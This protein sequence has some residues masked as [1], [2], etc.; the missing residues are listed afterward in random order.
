MFCPKC[1]AQNKDDQKFCRSCGQ[2]LPAVRMA[3]EGKVDDVATTLTKSL[4]KMASGA[5]TMMIFMVIAF[6]ANLFSGDRVTTT[7]NLFL[8]LLIGAPMVYAGVKRLQGQIKMLNPNEQPKSLPKT[9]PAVLVQPETPQ[10]ALPVVP[11][12]DPLSVN[13]SLVSV[14]EHTTFQL[15]HPEQS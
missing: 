8:G 7:L 10:T 15:K 12:T 2:S 1:G 3:L 9:E 4:D 11:D 13:P 5:L 14:T 6:F